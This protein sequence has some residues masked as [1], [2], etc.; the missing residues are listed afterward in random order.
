MNST[1]SGKN[2]S[3][4]GPQNWPGSQSTDRT[5]GTPARLEARIEASRAFS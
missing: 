5:P 3:I 1:G 4:E 2:S